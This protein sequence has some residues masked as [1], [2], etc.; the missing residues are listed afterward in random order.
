M[1]EKPTIFI[2]INIF[3]FSVLEVAS[4]E[5]P[6]NKAALESEAS[7]YAHEMSKI[8]VNDNQNRN[9]KGYLILFIYS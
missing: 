8:A 6:G 9:G 7:S 3:T 5:H 2:I 4:N 1:I